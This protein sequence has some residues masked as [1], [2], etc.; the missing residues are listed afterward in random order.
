MNRRV[1]LLALEV[2]TPL[3]VVAGWFVVSAGSTSLYYP[4]LADILQRFGQIWLGSGFVTDALP[5][6]GRM[7]AG[8]GIAAVAGVVVGTALGLSPMARTLLGPTVEFLRALP[9]VLLIPF[10]LVVFTNDTT[11]KVF[12]IAL[13]CSFPVI[14]NTVDGVRSVEPLQ[15]DVAQMFGFG[16]VERLWRVVLPSASPQIFA[17]LRASLSLALIL[18]VVSEMV[19]STNGIG[20]SILQSQRLFAT[21]DMWAGIV[22]LGVLGYLINTA[23]VVVEKRVLAWH[24]GFRASVLGS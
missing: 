16:R 13:G 2:L 17:G 9:A 11:L 8:Y 15:L 19:A 7:L 12:V 21:T 1:T 20:Y 23:L 3:A 18:M 6:L 10:A 4:P 22:L 14:L 24:R 5:S